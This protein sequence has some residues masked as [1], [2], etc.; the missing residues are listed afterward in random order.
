MKI[1]HIFITTLA[2]LLVTCK[3]TADHASLDQ[4]HDITFNFGDNNGYNTRYSS[5]PK[6]RGCEKYYW[7]SWNSGCEVC[8]RGYYQVKGFLNNYSCDQCAS[9]CDTCLSSRECQACSSGFFM[10]SPGACGNCLNGCGTCIEGNKCLRC[11]TGYFLKEDKTCE[12]C[13]S[14]CD[15]CSNMLTCETCSGAY[16]KN[17]ENKCSSC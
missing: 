13:T 4:N 9:G 8:V 12:L 17:T 3:K 6:I 16:F 7:A 2:V 15:V 1:A 11:K 5:R 10:V 14:G